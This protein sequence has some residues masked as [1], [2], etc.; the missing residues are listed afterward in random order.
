MAAIQGRHERP[1]RIAEPFILTAMLSLLGSTLWMWVRYSQ[2]LGYFYSSEFLAMTHLVTLGFVTSLMM[3]VLLKLAPMSLD[4]SPR[5]AGLARAQFLLFFVGA[6][7]MVY[8]FWIAEWNGLAWATLL[9]VAA[10]IVQLYNFSAIWKRARMDDWVAR[11]VAASLVYLVLAASLGA[12]LGFNKSLASGTGVLAGR[13]TSNL[14]AHVHLA[15]IGWVTM[16]IFGFLLKLVPTTKGRESTL[17]LRFWLMQVGTIGLAATLLADVR[18]QGLCALLLLVAVFWHAWGPV[19]AFVSGRAREWE[20]TPLVILCGVSVAGVLLAWDVP[21]AES[22]FRI[23]LQFAY[24]YA[25]F[26]GWFVLT[27]ATVAFKLFPI[28]VWQERFQPEYGKKPVPGMKSLYNNRL[29]VLSNF[30]LTTGVVATVAG[31]LA[32][33]GEIL[34]VSLGLVFGGAACFAVNFFLMARWALLRVEY[35]P[36]A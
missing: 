22:P 15:G 10:A 25:G 24:G 4:V 32:E 27:I 1:S 18:G 34:V 29:R 3:G 9:V 20:V 7:G 8:H 17:P 28:W 36:P 23:R 21:P 31:I 6:S 12:L 19:R 26:L 33:R 16:M 30:L 35:H 2:F 11:Y 13:F 5:S 14:F